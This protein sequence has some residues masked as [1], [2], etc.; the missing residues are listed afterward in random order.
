MIYFDKK[1]ADSAAFVRLSPKFIHPLL[2]AKINKTDKH[3]Y[4]TGFG[5]WDTKSTRVSGLSRLKNTKK[6]TVLPK[7]VKVF[8]EGLYLEFHHKIQEDSLNPHLFEEIK[9]LELQK[10]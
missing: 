8:K 4:L 3:L 10:K 7:Q 5:I 9:A 1:Q 2:K 6:K